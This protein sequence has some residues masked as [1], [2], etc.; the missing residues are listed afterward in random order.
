V[1]LGLLT[2]LLGSC[3]WF[4]PPQVPP[5]ASGSKPIAVI[6]ATPPSG[7]APLDVRFDASAS[8]D[9]VGE[10]LACTWFFGDG[11]TAA[12]SRVTHTYEAGGTYQVLLIVED[13]E[14]TSAT[15]SGT[16]EVAAQTVQIEDYTSET[17]AAGVATLTVGG[18]AVTITVVLPD[19][20]PGAASKLSSSDSAGLGVRVYALGK[21]LGVFIHDDQGRYEPAITVLEGGATAS[22]S[23][24]VV[25]ATLTRVIELS[26]MQGSD[27]ISVV[28]RSTFTD[29]METLGYNPFTRRF[30]FS[31]STSEETVQ[32]ALDFGLLRPA[33][34]LDADTAPEGTCTPYALYIRQPI[35]GELGL[36][37]GSNGVA[38]VGYG[39]DFLTGLARLL[40]PIWRKAATVTFS[41]GTSGAPVP[42]S[43]VLESYST[44]AS[45][46]ML[47]E[48]GNSLTRHFQCS[49]SGHVLEYVQWGFGDG[50]SGQGQNQGQNVEHTYDRPGAYEIAV[51]AYDS[52]GTQFHGS[53]HVDIPYACAAGQYNWQKAVQYAEDWWDGF[54]KPPY[55][56]YSPYDCANFASQCL[57]NGGVDLSLKGE[58][59]A[60]GEGGTIRSSTFLAQYLTECLVGVKSGFRAPGE[61]DPDWFSPGDVAIFDA[62]GTPEIWV[63]EDEAEV[64]HTVFAVGYHENGTVICAAHST[65]EEGAT[66]KQFLA[67]NPQ[68]KYC[69]YYHIPDCLSYNCTPTPPTTLLDAPQLQ[70]P[71]DRATDQPLAVIL[72]W[73]P[74]TG[75][76]RYWVL[77]ATD[78]SALPTDVNATDCSQCLYKTYTRANQFS[79]NLES[80]KTY[81][82]R[83]Q[84]FNDAVSP[85]RQGNYS[86]IRS[87]STLGGPCAY[88]LSSYEQSFTNAASSGSFG[89]E[90][91]A[92]CAWT[93]TTDAPSWVT[94]TASGSPGTGAVNYTVGANNTSLPRTG[95]IKVQ[96]KTFTISQAGTSPCTYAL[97]LY[98]QTYTDAGSHSASFGVT[99][100]AGCAWNVTVAADSTSWVSATASTP[101][102][103]G[104]VNYTIGTNPDPSPRTGRI[105]VQDKTFTITQAAKPPVV[106]E[107]DHI[108]VSGPG[109][110][111]EN[112][113]TPFTCTAYFTDT[114]ILDAT[115]SAS[116]SED[117]PY[118]TVSGGS[119]AVGNLSGDSSCV[120][121]ASYTDNGINKSTFWV[122]RLLDVV[123]V[124]DHITVSGPGVVD[125]NSSADF[126][127]TAYFSDGSAPVVTSSAIWT[128]ASSSSWVPLPTSVTIAGGRLSVG[129]L[130][131]DADCVVTAAYTSGTTTKYRG[132]A[133]HLHDTAPPPLPPEPCVYEVGPPV[134]AR[135]AASGGSGV[136]CVRTA[137]GCPWTAVTSDSWIHITT[138]RDY[139]GNGDV[140]YTVDPNREGERS[141]TITAARKTCTIPQSQSSSYPPVA[142]ITMSAQGKT[143]YEGGTLNLTMTGGQPVTVQFSAAR[144]SVDTGTPNASWSVDDFMASFGSETSLSFGEA[145]TYRIRLDVLNS[146]GH[147]SA[148]AEA[149]VVITATP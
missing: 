53:T 128:C 101:T 111:Y 58:G 26:L 51:T 76:N 70:A 87:F 37:T 64:K 21:T 78:S 130:D 138:G 143:A 89:V 115:G 23:M 131:S 47:V 25:G 77:L 12:G 83:V 11:S 118:A 19:M 59:V 36:V 65:K 34:R 68:W 147:T 5:D 94:M 122:V 43:A 91:S 49:A 44:A 90:T 57:M 117:S 106:K 82:W 3:T 72:Q 38:V 146:D 30:P 31:F 123:T 14:G 100:G 121:R 98:S 109:V 84:G 71:M 73:A 54:K 86:D 107:L 144:S 129:S 96:D 135:V 141:G 81:F 60:A 45:L 39:P 85:I 42:G 145:R 69:T 6:R 40:T 139:S 63:G 103:S 136:V 17:D 116:W 62:K 108:V 134:A 148:S 1:L 22:S 102:G 112:T 41:V 133:V 50:R 74:V 46:T 124:L 88:A 10:G 75:A 120:L 2:I 8:S 93:A 7:T 4:T 15:G 104:R 18:E 9:P 27:G 13:G 20:S 99:T 110:V 33:L 55:E 137:T 114:T 140:G 149:Q 24:A 32:G 126:V 28:T 79:V 67:A 119:L 125:E 127:C 80:G 35:A 95:R 52:Y 92:G 132:V 61:D 142:R 48:T 66:I 29:A 113:V 97:S 16:V 56:N 105:L